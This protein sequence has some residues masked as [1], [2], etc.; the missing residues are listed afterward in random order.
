ML[1]T[2]RITLVFLFQFVLTLVF[3]VYCLL[4]VTNFAEMFL[5]N[6]AQLH[7]K[8]EHDKWLQGKCTEQEFVH[9]IRHHIDL[10]ESVERDALS[11]S[12]LVAMQMALDGLHLCGSYSCE[13]IALALTESFHLSI[14]TWIATIVVALVLFPLC[15]M[16]LYKKWQ[17]NLLLHEN[18]L[19][20]HNSLVPSVYI[21]DHIGTMQDV[22]LTHLDTLH[23]PRNRRQ[24]GNG[25]GMQYTAQTTAQPNINSIADM[26]FFGTSGDTYYQQQKL[27]YGRSN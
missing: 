19:H 20:T 4:I 8:R 21:R 26:S 11:N 13:R 23:E 10:C 25:G 5:A 1:Y 15:A 7:R 27:Q 14:Y 18:R 3:V 16:P 17:R 22:P 2:K 12:Y 6:L 24:I 9:H